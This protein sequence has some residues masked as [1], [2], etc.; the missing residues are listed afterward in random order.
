[1]IDTVRTPDE[2]QDDLDRLP[3]AL[4]GLGG[5]ARTVVGLRPRRGEP[6]VRE[7]QTD[8]WKV[9]GSKSWAS[10]DMPAGLDCPECGAALVLLLRVDSYE[11]LPLV[12]ENPHTYLCTV[13]GRHVVWG[14][15]E[16]ARSPG[17]HPGGRRRGRGD[18]RLLGRSAA[19]G[20][21]LHP[22]SSGRPWARGWGPAPGQPAGAGSCWAI[23]WSTSVSSRSRLA[24]RSRTSTM[25]TGT[26]GSRSSASRTSASVRSRRP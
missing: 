7:S 14:T 21:V 25:T 17:G 23:S 15:E 4:P 24:S 10:S 6:G 12:S 1:M 9:G 3:A 8:G 19:P 2:G 5:L 20:A 26:W 11:A 22:V 18:T 13:T 16:C